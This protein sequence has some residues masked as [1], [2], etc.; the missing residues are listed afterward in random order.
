MPLFSRWFSAEPSRY[1]RADTPLIIAVPVMSVV[2]LT[3]V[4]L[5]LEEMGAVKGFYASPYVLL[6]AVISN[7]VCILS[8]LLAATLGALAFNMEFVQPRNAFTVPTMEELLAY[9]SMLVAAVVVARRVPAK[10]AEKTVKAGDA[11][12]FVDQSVAN[13]WSVKSSGVWGDDTEVGEAYGRMFVAETASGRC[14]IPLAWV[15]RSMVKRGEYTGVE[16]GFSSVVHRSATNR[17][18][19]SQ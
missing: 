16:A 5:A 12:P 4:G 8:G 1:V 7:R 2:A 18:S 14:S 9:L 13:F 19:Q 6:A 3:V 10:P 11:L 17:A 15:I